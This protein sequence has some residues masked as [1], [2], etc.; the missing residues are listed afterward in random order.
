MD[1]LLGGASTSLLFLA[2][3]S[4]EPDHIG[5]AYSSLLLTTDPS[6]RR[7]ARPGPP[8]LG[9]SLAIAAAAFAADLAVWATWLLKV[10][11]R[12]QHDAQISNFFSHDEQLPVKH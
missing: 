9:M 11:R 3:S 10:S 4:A 2:D 6:R 8:M 7:L 12:V 1:A 5:A